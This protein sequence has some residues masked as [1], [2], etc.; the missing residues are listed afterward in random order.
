MQ[1]S[2]IYSE[3]IKTEASI[4]MTDIALVSLAKAGEQ[5]AYVELIQRHSKMAM[6]MIMRILRNNE[7]SEDVLQDSILKAYVHLQGF[8]GR[9][10][11][12]TWFAR[13]AVNSALMVL[14]KRRSRVIQS[15]DDLQ[16]TSIYGSIQLS[17]QTDDPEISIVKS[18]LTAQLRTAIR[19]LPPVLRVV[20]EIRQSA[21][22]SVVEVAA[23]AGLT[24]AATKSRLLRA[25]RELSFMMNHRAP[26]ANASRQELSG[27][28]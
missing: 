28:Q 23:L 18:D 11:F 10:K 27:I 17:E 7:D 2:K 21:D 26:Y 9:S 8:D 20:T 3:V 25:R 15:I 24:V 5:A 6:R 22:L 14:R 4:L 12:S 16:E 1:A 13:I 19:R